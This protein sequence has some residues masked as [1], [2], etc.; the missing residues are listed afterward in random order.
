[1]SVKSQAS[2][3][4]LKIIPC[5]V[6]ISFFEKFSAGLVLLLLVSPHIVEAGTSAPKRQLEFLHSVFGV[7]RLATKHYFD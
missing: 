3:R 4:G 2:K 6:L 7:L 5:D 1:M